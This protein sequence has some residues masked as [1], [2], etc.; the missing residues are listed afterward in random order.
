L[1]LI[2]GILFL[3]RWLKKREANSEGKNISD[4]RIKN[5]IK[6]FTLNNPPRPG[7]HSKSQR[8]RATRQDKKIQTDKKHHHHHQ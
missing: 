8:K 4:S 6:I 1:S 7:T 2:A 5:S 3:R